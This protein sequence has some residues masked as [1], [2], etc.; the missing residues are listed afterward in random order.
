VNAPANDRHLPDFLMKLIASPPAAGGGVH[1]WLFQ[2]A[3][4]LHAHLSENEIL[5]LLRSKV[6]RC[7]RRVPDREVKAAIANARGYAWKP[8]GTPHRHRGALPARAALHIPD[9]VTPGPLPIA[10]A[11]SD[12][13]SG[14]FAPPPKPDLNKIDRLL[15][16]NIGVADLMHAS[17]VSFDS[18]PNTEEIVDILFPPDCL[19]CC[20]QSAFKFNTL[21][22]TLWRDSLSLMSF[23]VP[24]TMTALTGLTKD[25]ARESAHT[26]AN[27]GPRRFLVV[28]FDFAEFAR[29]G[30]TP[31]PFRDMLLKY[32]ARKRTV[33]DLCANLLLR[34]NRAV[35]MVM[36]VHSGGKSVH[37]WWYCSGQPEPHVK[38]FHNYAV[39]LGADPA[40]F[41]RSQFVRMPDGTRNE[42]GNPQPVLYFNPNAL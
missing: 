37:G 5:A 24:S 32:K 41:R 10:A 19:L 33:Q 21:P 4:N 40:T 3:R 14:Q 13:Y 11:S 26:L 42:N 8:K 29:D 6:D 2:V 12:E 20:G 36:A 22:R 38:S 15:A 31:T 35:P 9:S 1:D 17:P 34:L 28:E 23:L 25:G 7:G 16:D 27:T 30:K 18:Y 39:S